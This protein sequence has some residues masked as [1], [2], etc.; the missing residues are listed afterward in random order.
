MTDSRENSL[1]LLRTLLASQ[2]LAVVATYS[3]KAPYANL[4]AFAADDDLRRLV[5]VTSRATT[6]YRNLSAHP[7]AALLIDNRARAPE[8]FSTGAAVTAVGPA[9]EV[10]DA[11]RDTWLNRFLLKH[12]Y[13]DAF[14][15]AP[16]TAM[17]R[18]D[19]TAYYLVTRFQHVVEMD[20][21]RWPSSSH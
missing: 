8:D 13:L 3:G 10:G 17:F 11:E 20:V 16:S 4:V 21:S 6:K 15:H 7:H 12:P 18:L 19:V 5:F 1:A 2:G 9:V 14:A